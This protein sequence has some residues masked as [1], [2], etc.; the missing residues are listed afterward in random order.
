ML[1]IAM[2]SYK[3][4]NEVPSEYQETA[5]ALVDLYRLRTAQCLTIADITRP[6]RRLLVEKFSLTDIG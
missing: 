4:M 1:C 3:R 5:P 2:H 6:V